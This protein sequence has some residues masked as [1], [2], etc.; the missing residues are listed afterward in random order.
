[1]TSRILPLAFLLFGACK[2]DAPP[3]PPPPPAVAKDAGA[4]GSGSGGPPGDVPRAPIY[5]TATS[6][7]HVDEKFVANGQTYMVVSESESA[8][9]VGRD[10]LKAGGNAVDAAVA[11]AFALAVTH[12]S[13]GNLGGGGFAVVRDRE[14]KPYALDFRETA[15]A[16]A[17][18]DMYL[19]A[20][21]KPTKDSTIGHRSSG[22]PGS[23]AGLWELHKKLG[24]TPWKELVDPAIRLARDGFAV[25]PVLA[26]SLSRRAEFLLKHPATAEIWVPERVPRA[27]GATVTIPQLALA[28]ER[29]RDL[30]PDGFYKGETAKAI[31]DE[32]ARGKG[33]ITAEDLAGYRAVW[34]EPLR[35]TY[36]GHTLTSMP[37]P[38]SGGVVLAMIAGMLANQD[39]GKMPWH[40]VDHVRWL[41]ETWRRAFAKRNEVLGDPAFVKDMPLSTLLSKKYLEELA[42]TIGPTATPSADIKPFAEGDHTT[43]L[44]VVDAEGMAIALTTTLNTGFGSGI[45]IHGFLMNNEMDDFAIKPGTPN[46]YGLVQWSKNKIEPGKRM[47]SSMTPT[48]VEDASGQVRLV[49]G[50]QGGPRIITAVWQS[51]S[52]VIDF[53]HAVGPAVSLP[54]VHHQHLPDIVQFE[55]HSVEESVASELARRGYKPDFSSPWPFGAANM[56]LRTKQG[57]SAAA[58]WRG[59][60][61]ARG[62]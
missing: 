32:M 37:P 16:A 62:D 41:T 33:L 13:A 21:G 30:G 35:F 39:L 5:R 50:A 26:Q 42:S 31:V 57:W 20:D 1:M 25:D 34:R 51:I 52:N 24:K 28:L 59:G 22:V 9:K 14:R 8:T 11:T 27:A 45:T 61:A 2:R 48:I 60:G 7:D 38:S 40:G 43:N 46:T 23:V 4:A 49:A 36:R 54:R 3:A 47:L 17:T 44:C 55:A 53:G 19:D 10:V 29:I 15:P 12:P 18:A 56:I 58:D 6:G